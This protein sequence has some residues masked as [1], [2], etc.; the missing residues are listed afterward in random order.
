MRKFGKESA[1]PNDTGG[2]REKSDK[3]W[4]KNHWCALSLGVIVIVAFLLRTVFAFGLSADGD[5]ALSGGSSAQYHLHVIESILNGNY[6]LTDAAVNYPAGGLMVYPPL[7]DFLAAIV[8]M[9]LSAAGMGTTAAAS[10][11]IGV[12]NPIIGAL[13]CVPVFLVAR[14]LY[15]K[16]AG[17]VAALVFA[18]LALPISTSVFSSGTEYALA[19]FLVA[20]MSLFLVK[21]VKAMDAEG[22]SRKP[23]YIN[24]VLAGVFLALAALTWNGFRILL[25]LLIVA[26]VA[27]LLVDRFKGRDVTTALVAYSVAMLVGVVVAALYYVPAGLW[28]AVFSGPLLITVVAIV[29][30]F[31]FKA[32]QSKPWVVTIPALVVVFIAFLAVLYFAV[33]DLFTAFVSGNSVY[34]S[35]I[36]ASLASGHVSMS[37]VAAYYGWLTIWLPICLAIYEFYAFF[38]KERSCTRLFAAVWLLVLFLSAWT[39]YA[40]AAV[41]GVVFGVGSGA[42]IVKVLEKADLGTWYKNMKAAGFPGFLRKMIKPFPFV[43]VLVV[44]LLV[45]VPNFTFAVDAGMP[46]NDADHAF[47]GNTSFVIKTGDSYPIGDLW[48]QYSEQ[49]KS[50]ALVNWIDYTYD[51]V[52]QGK[53]TTVTDLVGGGSS[54]AAQIYLS[55]GTAG[56]LAAMIM[57]LVLDSEEDCSSLMP[58]TV[59]QYIADPEKAIAEIEAN[60]SVYGNLRSDI[61]D[62]NAIYLASVQYMEE[63][64]TEVQINDLYDSVYKRTGN[65]IS[66]VLADG[67]MLPIQYGDSSSFSTVAYFA[68]YS[69]DKYGAASQYYSINTYYGYSQYTDAIY[70][71]F[72]WK[73]LIGPSAAEAGYTSSYSYLVALSS[74]NGEE[75]S[76]KAIPGYGLSGYEVAFWNVKYNPDN[77]ATA[78]SDGWVYMN[79]YDAMAKQKA[80]GGVIN[81]LSSI[82]LLEY[83]SPDFGYQ[84]VDV[85]D[86]DGNNVDGATISVYH[87]D[88]RV[89]QYVLFSEA[90]V[91]NGSASVPTPMTE[92][93][94]YTV[95]VGGNVVSTDDKLDSTVTIGLVD[96]YG[97]IELDGKVIENADFELKLNGKA[98]GAVDSEK[99]TVDDGVIFIDGVLPDTYTYTLYDSTG[100]S[101]ATGTVTPQS[102]ETFGFTVSPK[103]YNI[104]V[105]VNDTNGQSVDEGVVIATNTSTGAQFQKEVEDGKAVVAVLP[106]TYTISMGEGMVTTSTTSSNASSGNRST[107]VTAYPAQTVTLLGAP[108]AVYTATAGSFS[109]VS[110]IGADGD[111]KVDL[112]VSI[113]TDK[114]LYTIYGLV[115][116]KVYH[117]DYTVGDGI[118]L[119]DDK[120]ATVTGTL[121]NGENGVSGTVS[122][123]SDN[124]E[125]FSV[126]ADSEGKF[127]AYIPADSYTVYADNGSDKVFIGAKT[128]SGSSDIGDISLVDG[129]KITLTFRYDPQISGSS[130]VKIPYVMS[131]IAFTYN[132]VEYVLNG[133]TGTDGSTSFYIPDDIDSVISL[134]H[135][136][137]DNAAF[138]CTDLLK[139]I[140]AGTS[141]NSNYITVK[142]QEKDDDKNVLKDQGIWADDYEMTLTLYDDDEK[143]YEFV[144]GEIQQIPVGQYDVVI[145]GSDGYYFKGTAYVYPGIDRLVGLE[146]EEVYAV[147]ITKAA[148]DIL[149]IETEDGAYHVSGTT[150]YFEKGYEYFLK[151][152]RTDGDKK[153]VAYGYLDATSELPTTLD[154]TASSERMTV[155]GYIGTSADGTITVTYGDVKVDFEVS[156]G[157]YSLVLPSS[158]TSAD[159]HVKVTS[160]ID[161]K[162]VT[163]VGDRSVTGMKD[164]DVRNVSVLSSEEEEAKAED[165]P[166]YEAELVSV[167]IGAGLVIFDIKLTNNTDKAMTFLITAGDDWFLGSDA[168]ITLFAGETVTF[169][170][171]G[172]YD[173]SIVALGSKGMTV[174]I[175]DINGSWTETFKFTDATTVD[176][177]QKTALGQEILF[178]NNGG[179][180]DKVSAF[181]YMYAITIENKDGFA[182]DVIVNATAATGWYVTIMD[183]DGCFI[184]EV[185][186]V[187]KAYGYQTSVVYVKVM[188]LDGMGDN[189]KVPSITG[190]VT[191]GDEVKSINLDPETISLSTDSMSASG[192]N[193]F[194]ELSSIPAGIWFMVAVMVLLLIAIFWLGSKRGVFSRKN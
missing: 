36:M 187:V 171:A 17:V 139:E 68:G 76:A 9:I 41:I 175:A 119:F 58:E 14:E 194:N 110:Y 100:A 149:K 71:T 191:V 55:N 69:V 18:F 189:S 57:R 180:K 62:E 3:G 81:Y 54:A 170:A 94:R 179:K 103:S 61:T 21:M 131:T 97:T 16:K 83:V 106:G 121:K 143:V 168:D 6:S 8:A 184:G 167:D 145:D 132:D 104:T 13:T 50:G 45:V 142:V 185:G 144:A 49:E 186:S 82:V 164:G 26:M 64:M 116:G 29:F 10:A 48:D 190:T 4:L 154:M 51:A 59:R 52:S 146:V 155:T 115:D 2:S 47:N 42:A 67:S 92:K 141:N 34:S 108:K 166:D 86:S 12:L 136:E 114:M 5:F 24:A 125:V 23:V 80:E 65:K 165:E 135:G 188:P 28:D 93:V 107:T 133:M 158:V 72:L 122:F 53:F 44:A 87:Y 118:S 32:V 35:S 99:I 128:V 112:P 173:E 162:D 183:E 66:Y 95:S 129:R 75:G 152:E 7:M 182:K 138:K 153:Y 193:I 151:S 140:S 147:V 73:M 161:G 77:Q 178:A 39:T 159:L 63:N 134:N 11:G 25:V 169:A 70:D 84:L 113:G 120:I 98:T 111:V 127:T 88:D 174:T 177:E 15:G 22:E 79:G 30:G 123:I 20:F 74:S 163:F 38:K 137:L 85:K 1:A 160:T 78:T 27:Q 156:G 181:E 33:P 117:A 176:E 40:N 60:P 102:G 126:S 37:N 192:D 89:G 130:N 43:S 109:T 101:V 56:S 90:R 124:D 157:S 31:L 105:T 150:Y 46:A 148:G 91:I 19:A 96:I 172:L